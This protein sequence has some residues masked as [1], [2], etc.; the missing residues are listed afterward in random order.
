MWSHA[1]GIDIGGTTSRVAL[2]DQRRTILDLA[3]RPTPAGFHEL[4]AWIRAKYLAL[5]P[6]RAQHIPLGLALPGVVDRAKGMLVRSVNLSWLEQQPLVETLERELGIR[7][8]LT[9]DAEAATWAEYVQCVAAPK[10]FAHLRLGTGVACGV[11][12][13]GALLPTDPARRDHWPVLIVDASASAPQ[14]PCG[15]RGCLELYVSGKMLTAKAH[16]LGFQELADLQSSFEAGDPSVVAVLDGA[17]RAVLI[18]IANLT[19]QFAVETV[20]MGGGV[21]AALPSL[22]ALIQHIHERENPGAVVALQPSRLGDDA[23]I[24]GAADLAMGQQ[25]AETRQ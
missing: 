4:T 25:T 3:R 24:I 1:I 14:C 22:F 12:I 2:V 6:A 21:L 18:A 16:E 5:I 19:R 10:S 23:G 17:A 15:L 13:E 9:T 20:V 8:H 11:V 7:A